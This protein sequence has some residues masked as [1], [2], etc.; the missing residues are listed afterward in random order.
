M[1]FLIIEMT[2]EEKEL[3]CKVIERI[4]KEVDKIEE[5]LMH[6]EGENLV[7]SEPREIGALNATSLISNFLHYTKLFPEKLFESEDGE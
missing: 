2:K 4:K 7:A 1:D 5:S 6:K 3:V